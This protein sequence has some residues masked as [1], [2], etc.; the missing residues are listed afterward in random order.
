[1]KRVKTVAIIGVGLIGGSLGMALKKKTD[2]RI[3]GIGR[4]RHKL[5]KALRCRA[6]DEITTDF[7]EGAKDADVLV[8]AT[9]VNM[10]A[11][12]IKRV[13]PRLKKG[14]VITD[15]GSVKGSVIDEVEKVIKGKKLYFVGAHPMAGS[16]Q[17]GI[18]V[19]KADLFRDAVCVITPSETSSPQA[20]RAVRLIW[21]KT[22]AK[23]ISMPSKKHDN[24][25]SYTSHLPHVL[26]FS[27]VSI[28]HQMSKKDKNINL[29]TAGSFKDL[30][31]VASSDPGLWT[32]ICIQNK[33]S[34]VSA[35]G[36]FMKIL[37][38]AE[39]DIK[40]SNRVRL[41]KSFSSAKY[42]RDSILNKK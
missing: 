4:H 6:V 8:V 14:C 25:V 9:P 32:Q 22:G 15:V 41:L 19:A 18:E 31:R 11:K 24:M 1:M 21:Q 34:M 2:I 35:I 39:Q 37:R 40:R 28:V 23:I 27:L 42:V 7:L 17:K 33:K 29:L 20:I 5:E 16:E 26:A 13:L 30:T 38:K 3:I 36:Q 10:I 12:T